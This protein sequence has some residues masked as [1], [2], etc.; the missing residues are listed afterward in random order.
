M[1]MGYEHLKSPS[2]VLN[3]DKTLACQASDVLLLVQEIMA[4]YSVHYKLTKKFTANRL[5]IF[6]RNLC[7][8][9]V[10]AAL[11]DKAA[12]FMTHVK[13]DITFSFYYKLLD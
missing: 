9:F 3:F 1:L 13:L 10:P 8:Y 5:S 11:F 12:N 7:L 2:Y 6:T 4:V